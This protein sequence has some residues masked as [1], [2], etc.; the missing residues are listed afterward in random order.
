MVE[1]EKV[2]ARLRGRGRSVV[3]YDEDAEFHIR[4]VSVDQ[5]MASD[6]FPPVAEIRRIVKE[7]GEQGA[8]DAL[9][10]HF[11][12]R[13]EATQEFIENLIVLGS[14][15]PRIV[16]GDY[17]KVGEG[18]LHIDDVYAYRVRLFHDI[19]VLSGWDTTLLR[20]AAFRDPPR[21]GEADPPAREGDGALALGG[22]AYAG[23]NLRD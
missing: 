16:K 5:I 12:E 6:A 7:A 2:V 19:M 8:L 10:K 14:L 22:L 23:R 4:A 9:K 3:K 21:A 13:R 15:S 1:G 20:G 11:E 17:D 18:E